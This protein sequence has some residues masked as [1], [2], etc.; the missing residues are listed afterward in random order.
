[1]KPSRCCVSL[2]NEKNHSE[3]GFMPFYANQIAPNGVHISISSAR[4]FWNYIVEMKICVWKSFSMSLCWDSPSDHFRF[5][6]LQ[7]AP[8]TCCIIFTYFDAKN[9]PNQFA[10][11]KYFQ[12]H[13]QFGENKCMRRLSHDGNFVKS[14]RT[15]KMQFQRCWT[16]IIP[17]NSH[18]FFGAHTHT[19]THT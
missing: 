10:S 8:G 13:D 15:N 16:T 14:E 6:A 5:D 3:L 4:I 11:I 2:S 17:N 9:A 1:M 19:H 7:T 18:R 12:S